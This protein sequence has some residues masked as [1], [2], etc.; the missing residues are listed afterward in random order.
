[1]FIGTRNGITDRPGYFTEKIVFHGFPGQYSDIPGS[2]IMIVIMISVCVDKMGAVASVC[3]SGLIHEFHKLGNTS[4]NRFRDDI[5]AVVGR[6]KHGAVKDVNEMHFFSRCEIHGGGIGRNIDSRFTDSDRIVQD[7]VAFS[8]L[9]AQQN[10]QDFGH[11][12]WITDGVRILFKDDLSFVLGNK[13]G[14]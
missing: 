6:Q 4:G 9:N 13:D 7:S 2:G 1:M 14:G 8:I 3:C 5:G 10:S 11:G 12:C